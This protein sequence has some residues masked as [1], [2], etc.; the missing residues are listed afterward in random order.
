MCAAESVYLDLPAT[1]KYLAAVSACVGEMLSALDGST[2]VAAVSQQVQL[3]VH[4]AC[5]NIVDHAYEGMVKGR[6][7][8]TL[9]LDHETRRFV[10]ELH[11]NG[12]GFDPASVAEPDLKSGQ[13]H[14]YGLFIIRQVMDE[15]TYEPAAGSNRWR[16]VKDV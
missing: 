8:I 14:G 4:E 3:A 5:A 13:V 6:M 7:Q 1:G 11:D 16:L 2:E 9:S 10:V 12:K 15:V